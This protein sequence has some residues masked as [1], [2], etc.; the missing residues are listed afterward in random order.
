MAAELALLPLA[1]LILL[2][3]LVLLALL[4]L[5]ALLRLPALRAFPALRA[6]FASLPQPALLLAHET[7]SL[8]PPRRVHCGDRRR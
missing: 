5:L 2:R 1:A 7:S 3:V 8:L 4:P 6:A